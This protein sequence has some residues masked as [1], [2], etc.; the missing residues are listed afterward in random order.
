MNSAVKRAVLACAFLAGSAA[1]AQVV[2][3]SGATT[4][5]RRVLEPGAEALKA[6]TGVQLKVYGPGT[7]KGMLALFEGKVP[8]AAAGESLDDAVASAKAAAA[9]SGRNAIVP[10]N[11]QYH[12]VAYDNIVV[13]VHPGNTVKSLNRQQLKDI[14]TGK[15]RNWSEVGGPN[16]PIKV[17]AAA[18]GQAVRSLV[19]KSWMDG[20]DYAAGST[21]IRTALEQLRV[22]AADP[23]AVGA[24]SEP[25]IKSG[26]EKLRVVPGAVISRPLGFVTVGAPSGAV[27]KT[28]DYFRSP[29]GQ[30]QIR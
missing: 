21:E 1:F 27:L 7:G 19:Q 5:Q 2:E 4:M 30:K 26:S 14:L 13:A 6:A 16:L 22:I 24:M 15:T 10:A 28:V 9:E 8:L 11:L 12:Q 3:V 29:E 18:Q 20:A 25:V 23:A 17:I